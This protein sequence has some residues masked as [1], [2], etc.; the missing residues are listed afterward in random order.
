MEVGRLAPPFP[1]VPVTFWWPGGRILG[2]PARDPP[3]PPPSPA[4]VTPTLDVPEARLPTAGSCPQAG[5]GGVPG[6]ENSPARWTEDKR[7]LP[8]GWP[9][10]RPPPTT[11]SRDA[12]EGQ[13]AWAQTGLSEGDD[14]LKGDSANRA[15]RTRLS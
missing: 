5:G 9:L 4:P 3:S 1:P 15:L 13:E 10:L 2:G 12:G 8:A 7:G 6:L 11:S 14:S